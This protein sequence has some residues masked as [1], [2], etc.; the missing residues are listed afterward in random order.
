MDGRPRQIADVRD[1]G[2]SPGQMAVTR[3]AVTCVA[4]TRQM[5]ERT[6]SER[7]GLL[8]GVAGAGGR[9]CG[10]NEGYERCLAGLGKKQVTWAAVKKLD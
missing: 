2:G 9:D 7:G 3:T 5:R 1:T 10:G 4:A 8:D 6:G